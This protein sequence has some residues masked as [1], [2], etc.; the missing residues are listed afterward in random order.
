M[1]ETYSLGSD[2]SQ[3]IRESGQGPICR[4]STARFEELDGSDGFERHAHI[5]A[6]SGVADFREPP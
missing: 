4:L 6:K 3:L 5:L 1:H 2:T